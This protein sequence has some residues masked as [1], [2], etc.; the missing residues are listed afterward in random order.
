MRKPLTT[1]RDETEEFVSFWNLWRPLARHTDG[2]GDARD[3]FF[4]HIRAGVDP[5]D[6][7]D[8]ARCFL[9][10]MSERDREYIPLAS[11]WLNKRAYEDLAEQER[12]HQARVLESERR[13]AQDMTNVVQITPPASEQID[14]VKRAE[15][16]ARLKG[17]A[18]G[19]RA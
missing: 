4:Q 16:A 3:T 19:M 15:M 5:Q 9:R 17:L 13:R 11:S 12:A 14:P 8:G 1:K 10:T 6:I 7:V 2:R 18:R